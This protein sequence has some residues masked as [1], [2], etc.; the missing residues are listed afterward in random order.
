MRER[1]RGICREGGKGENNWPTTRNAGTSAP[2]CTRCRHC[3]K[4]TVALLYDLLANPDGGPV[5]VRLEP[6]GELSRDLSE[7]A[8]RVK[9]PDRDWDF[10]GGDQGRAVAWDERCTHVERPADI[11]RTQL[12][13]PSCPMPTTLFLELKV[14]LT[15]QR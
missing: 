10:V 9:I 4:R 13:R 2:P 6:G 15:Y 12:P 3:T 7:G 8:G 14:P 11:V 1:R 5:Q